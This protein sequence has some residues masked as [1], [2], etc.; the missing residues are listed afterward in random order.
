MS[1]MGK[2]ILHIDRNKYYGGESTSL[3]PIKAVSI[4]MGILVFSI[5][6][7]F[8]SKNKLNKLNRKNMLIEC[9]VKWSTC[10]LAG[11]KKSCFCN[12][13]SHKGLKVCQKGSWCIDKWCSHCWESRSLDMP[14]LS[15]V[16]LC[17]VYFILRHIKL[18]FWTTDFHLI[19]FSYICINQMF[20]LNYI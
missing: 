6:Y 9:F 2:K 8:K 3:T 17:K 12:S 5:L 16:S 1:V 18:L 11:N 4:H 19:D 20:L 7:P 10:R 15:I 14:K 13:Y